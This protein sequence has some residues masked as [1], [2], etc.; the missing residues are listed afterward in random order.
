M[1]RIGGTGCVNPQADTGTSKESSQYADDVRYDGIMTWPVEGTYT[2][3]MGEPQR[4]RIV[5]WL[6]GIDIDAEDVAYV[7]VGRRSARI[8]TFARDAQGHRYLG[9][10][11][12]VVLQPPTSIK[13]RSFE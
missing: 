3:G 10:D 8:F 4:I 12:H 13:R 6:A 1:G 5:R 2:P 7:K 11:G 9:G